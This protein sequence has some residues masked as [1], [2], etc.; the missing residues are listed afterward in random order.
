MI[1]RRS[2]RRRAGGVALLRPIEPSIVG[3][4]DGIAGERIHSRATS[5][6]AQLLLVAACTV[7]RAD[8]PRWYRDADRNGGAERY[9]AW[10]ADERDDVLY[11]GLSPFWTLWWESG[12]DARLD[13]EVPGDLLIGRF[14]LRARRFRPALRVRGL[15][16]G[17]RGSIWDVLAHSNGRIYYTSFF[18]G[19]G[20]IAPDGGAG[21]RFAH[22]GVGFS[23]LV[24]GPGGRIYLTRYA[25][26]PARPGIPGYGAVTVVEPDGALVWETR[27]EPA[28]DGTH[29]APKS[30]AVDPGSGE[31]WV[32]TDS[33]SPGGA[34][35]HE[36]LRLS[37]Q[38]ELVERRAGG[39]ELQ[40]MA[41]TGPGEGWFALA[42]DG[43]LWLER[44]AP[45][46]NRALRLSPQGALDFVQDIQPGPHGSVVAT[47]WSG[48]AFEVRATG[49][50][51]EA[52]AVRFDL[53]PECA[54]PAH[55]SLTYTAVPWQGELYAT[56]FCGPVVLR[57]P[58]PGR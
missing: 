31:V 29:T 12:G 46:G 47:L 30:L 24:E 44:R 2:R 32:N 10:F 34:L 51:L 13:L 36:T 33:W 11:F 37:A 27:F 42:R 56:L 53:P 14:D 54:P 22:L 28:K 35:S 45:E 38:G 15:E 43:A 57:A 21:E 23:E 1:A 6:L 49:Q 48:R 19:A 39:E 16:E 17:A 58:L 52:R 5:G 26:E 8:A 50:G 4:L 41:F 18:E 20:W 25:A 3:A 7:P 9:S 55:R 40:F